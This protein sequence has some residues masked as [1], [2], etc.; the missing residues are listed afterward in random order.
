[1]TPRKQIK[2]QVE[3]NFV[4]FGG[5]SWHLGVIMFVFFD[6]MPFCLMLFFKRR[7]SCS[8]N[9]QLVFFSRACCCAKM[10]REVVLFKPKRCGFCCVF[11]CGLC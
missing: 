5:I 7:C 10:M 9:F 8:V 2:Q 4:G 11:S 3:V 1:M 6:M